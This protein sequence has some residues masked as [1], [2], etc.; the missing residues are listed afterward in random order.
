MR[1][2]ITSLVAHTQANPHKLLGFAIGAGVPILFWLL[3]WAQTSGGLAGP[4][5]DPR[6]AAFS[7]P[8]D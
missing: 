7:I 8:T 1:K 5:V 2:H 6:P 3:F 4:I